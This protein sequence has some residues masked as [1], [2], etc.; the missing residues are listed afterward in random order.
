MNRD[1]LV[2]MAR[3]NLEH[4]KA[5]TVDQADGVHRVPASNYVDQDRWQLEMDQIFRRLPLVLGFTA[6]L[7]EPGSYRSLIVADVPILLTRVANGE[8]RAF[9]NVCSHRGAVVVAEGTGNAT[10]FTCPYHA[11]SYD[12]EGALLGIYKQRDFGDLDK[13]CH[14]LTPLPVFER[15]GLIWGSLSKHSAIDFERFLSGYGDVLD[16]LGLAETH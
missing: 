6:E 4:V 13:D 2:R 3:R 7:R 12:N 10:R 15:S 1:E 9:V 16:A 8:I 14:G 5:E 11:W